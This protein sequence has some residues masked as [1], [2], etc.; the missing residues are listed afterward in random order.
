M[1]IIQS[2]GVPMCSAQ[3]TVSVYLSLQ[4]QAFTLSQLGNDAFS[5]QQDYN[6]CLGNLYLPSTG[7][8]LHHSWPAS[9]KYSIVSRKA[10]PLNPPTAKSRL[11]MTTTPT[12]ARGTLIDGPILQLCVSGSYTST[13]ARA[14]VPSLPPTTYNLSG[15]EKNHV[16]YYIIFT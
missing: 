14:M 5:W 16:Y 4:V 9:F 15:K 10:L 2:A 1:N 7:R 6:C 13:V 11:F 12:L 8:K 3:P